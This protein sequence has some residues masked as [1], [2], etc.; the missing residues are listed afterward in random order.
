MRKHQGSS[1]LDQQPSQS[2][3]LPRGVWV[4]IFLDIQLT[5]EPHGVRGTDP[6]GNENLCTV[7]SASKTKELIGTDK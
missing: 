1:P 6:H 2:L 3:P 7:I 5:P 4:Y